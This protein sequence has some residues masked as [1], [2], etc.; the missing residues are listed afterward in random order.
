MILRLLTFPLDS[1]IW[2]A[3][4][5]QERAI[6][7]LDDRENLQKKLTKL[8]VQF[9]LGEIEESEF[10]IQEEDLLKQMEE[11]MEA[12]DRQSSLEVEDSEA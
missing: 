1:F 9:D 12:S 2:V 8:Q 4:Q 5:V 7:E 11:Q 3:E 10:I 6:A